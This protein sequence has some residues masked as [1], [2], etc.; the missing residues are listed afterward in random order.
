[1]NKDEGT[2]R[3]TASG[4][5]HVPLPQQLSWDA[6][7]M[8]MNTD[9]LFSS[10]LNGTI[11]RVILTSSERESKDQLILRLADKVLTFLIQV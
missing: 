2:V 11:I 5:F 3:I 8:G 10:E 1:L 7:T 6:Q 4:K 9:A